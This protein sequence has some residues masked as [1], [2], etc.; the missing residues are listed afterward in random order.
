MAGNGRSDIDMAIPA[1]WDETL[2]ACPKLNA[3]TIVIGHAPANRG[4]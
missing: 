2:L 1:V 4:Q 3:T